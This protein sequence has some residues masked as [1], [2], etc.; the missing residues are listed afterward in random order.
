MDLD[1]DM[2]RW[3]KILLPNILAKDD[4]KPWSLLMPALVVHKQFSITLIEALCRT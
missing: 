2:N 1:T 4:I 3:N